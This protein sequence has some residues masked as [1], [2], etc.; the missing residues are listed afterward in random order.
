MLWSLV[1]SREKRR[2]HLAW[3]HRVANRYPLGKTLRM[4]ARWESLGDDLARI[5]RSDF[6]LRDD[7]ISAHSR[8]VPLPKVHPA[9]TED[10]RQLLR[11]LAG[12]AQREHHELSP[13]RT[14]H[15]ILQFLVVHGNIVR[16]MN[17]AAAPSAGI[18][19][20]SPYLDR[21]IVEGSLSLRI[22]DRVRQ[23]PAKP[24]LA[25]ARPPGMSLD[26]FLRRDKGDYTAE[27]FQQHEA[28]RPALKELFA[29]GSALEDLGLVSVDRI[30]R[31]INEFSVDGRVYT[32]LVY[33]AFAERW[34]RSIGGG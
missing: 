16:R 19:F 26:Y 18:H 23:Y 34:L 13:H 29:D 10:A 30:M 17:L 9:L 11:Q 4:V 25:A 8:W 15:Q 12:A 22:G 24:L 33:I 5:G 21:R 20:D 27:V 14:T 28:L 32:D 7:D 2:F 31:S 3:R 1:H 6:R